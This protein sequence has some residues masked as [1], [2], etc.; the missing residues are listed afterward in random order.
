MTEKQIKKAWANR[1]NEFGCYIGNDVLIKGCN[2]GNL[3]FDLTEDD[4][5]AEMTCGYEFSADSYYL[6]L[7]V[8]YGHWYAIDEVNE[9]Y[10]FNR[11]FYD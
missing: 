4:I 2:I 11:Y 10:L 7:D 1:D 6:V 3:D 5:K 9:D 8:S